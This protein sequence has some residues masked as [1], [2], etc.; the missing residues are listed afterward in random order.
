MSVRKASVP[1]LVSF[2]IGDQTADIQGLLT[3][4]YDDISE[5]ANRL[6]AWI[7][8]F[9]YQKAK[10]QERVI[11]TKY[12]LKEA[13]AKEYFRLRSGGFQSDGYGDKMTEAALER[14]VYLSPNVKAASEA[15]AKAEKDDDWL[16]YTIEAL[17]AKMELIRS[18]EATRR[19]ESEIDRTKGP[20]S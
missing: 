8:W 15:H 17:S 3:S 18:S 7:G 20:V 9:G 11:N 13:E 14:A 6:P 4:V 1:V 2:T 12:R 19:A 5:A 10:A 16:K